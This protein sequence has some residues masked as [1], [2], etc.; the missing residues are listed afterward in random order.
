MAEDIGSASGTASFQLIRFN[1]IGRDKARSDIWEPRGF[2]LIRFN[3]I[4]RG[5]NEKLHR[6]SLPRVSN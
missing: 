2:Q 3:P 5:K 1:P 4:G 6:C